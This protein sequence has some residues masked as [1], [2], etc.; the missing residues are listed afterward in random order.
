MSFRSI[1]FYTIRHFKYRTKDLGISNN[2]EF[3]DSQPTQ[4]RSLFQQTILPHEFCW[5]YPTQ[6]NVQDLN[7]QIS[8]C[9]A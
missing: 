4:S 8:S 7:A 6:G 5:Q 3:S 1:A 9:Y 2:A